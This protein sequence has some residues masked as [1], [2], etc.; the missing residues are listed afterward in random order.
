MTYSFANTMV[1][2]IKH[3]LFRETRALSLTDGVRRSS[4]IE[5]PVPREELL[6]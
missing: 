2:S 4:G 1:S 3:F 6:H 5:A